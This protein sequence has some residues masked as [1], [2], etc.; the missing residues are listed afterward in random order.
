MGGDLPRQALHLYL[1]LLL[2]GGVAGLVHA[3]ARRSPDR[4]RRRLLDALW[5]AVLLA[6][7]PVYLFVAAAMGWLD[8]PARSTSTPQPSADASSPSPAV[9]RTPSPAPAGE[10]R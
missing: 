7:A 5:V 6:G 1:P 8:P 2:L 9:P 10:G 3:L 4:R